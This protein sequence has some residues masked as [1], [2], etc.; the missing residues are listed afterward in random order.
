MKWKTFFQVLSMLILLIGAIGNFI[1]IK[2]LIEA[3]LYPFRYEYGGETTDDMEVTL[4]DPQTQQK[5][6][7][8][9]PIKSTI[10][11]DKWTGKLYQQ[12]SF[13]NTIIETDLINKKVFSHEPQ[14]E[15]HGSQ[16]W[17]EMREQIN[18]R[19]KRQEDMRRDEI[20][21]SSLGGR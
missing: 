19:L 3:H 9:L 14:S 5:L 18:A 6:Y 15:V 4:T 2:S 13:P 12:S 7:R 10:V 16:N 8:Y 20:L 11:L 21:K 17:D 1:P